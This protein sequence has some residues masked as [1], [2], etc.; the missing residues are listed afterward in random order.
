[1]NN[2][3]VNENGEVL[4]WRFS[5]NSFVG[6]VK[7][8]RLVFIDLKAK[9]VIVLSMINMHNAFSEGLAVAGNEWRW[10]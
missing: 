8:T 9:H 2:N 5:H 7:S 3:W 1:M 10:G 6:E 4:F